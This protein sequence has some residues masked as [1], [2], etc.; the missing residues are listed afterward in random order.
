MNNVI[1]FFVLF[2]IA[3]IDTNIESAKHFARYFCKSYNRGGL[4]AIANA[5]TDPVSANECR[6]DATVEP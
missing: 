1:M 6:H 3:K 2:V 5:M 4:N